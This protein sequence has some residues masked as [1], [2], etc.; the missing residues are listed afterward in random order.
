MKICPACD[1]SIEIDDDVYLEDGDEL[2]C[3]DCGSNLVF[4][5]NELIEFEEEEERDELI[6][7][8]DKEDEDDEEDVE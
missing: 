2:E 5:G 8:D 1:A 3:E 6:D 7:N 4:K